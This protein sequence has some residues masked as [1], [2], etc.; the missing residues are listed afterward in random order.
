[1]QNQARLK[2]QDKPLYG[3]L[4]GQLPVRLRCVF[5]VRLPKEESSHFLAFVEMTTPVDSGHA[6][7]CTELVRVLKAT[8]RAGETTRTTGY[9]VI[10]VAAIEGAAHLIP[11]FGDAAEKVEKG[12]VVNSH[13]DLNNWNT[14]YDWAEDEGEKV[15]GNNKAGEKASASAKRAGKEMFS[16]RQLKVGTRKGQGKRK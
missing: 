7:E 4:R 15:D 9:R 1:V 3:A 2:R 8:P 12:Y 14:V 16:V 13:I 11:D 6:E 5:K 10:E